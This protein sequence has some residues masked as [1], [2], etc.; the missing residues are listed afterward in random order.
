[1]LIGLTALIALLVL[2]QLVLPPIAER[3]V[4]DSL[5]KRGHVAS[6]QISAFPALKLLFGHADSVTVRMQDLQANVGESGDLLARAKA[7]GKLDVHIDR[8][9]LGPLALS[10]VA[11]RKRGSELTAS[12]ATTQAQLRASLP[13]G[14]DVQP[15]ASGNGEL[16][17]RA[18]ASLFGVGLAANAALEA[19]DGRLIV[20]P[21][22]IPF[23]SLVT[24]TV[25]ADQR[26]EVQGVGAS[27]ASGGY[28]L[29]AQAKL[30]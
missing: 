15:I 17:L 8:V 10:D 28:V 14:L 20:Q 23:G 22:G 18:S 16:L 4:R 5:A 19:R 9:T 7:T 11:L 27:P 13:P 6:V 30:R 21:V 29:N 12:A 24:L 3:R 1:V 25:F 2:A 26:I